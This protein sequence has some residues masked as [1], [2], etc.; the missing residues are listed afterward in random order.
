[1]IPLSA[2]SKYTV[3]KAPKGTGVHFIYPLPRSPQTKL[4]SSLLH[5]TPGPNS[6][7]L[8]IRS[9]FCAYRGGGVKSSSYHLVS[10]QPLSTN[11]E[12]HVC[13]AGKWAYSFDSPV[14]TCN[15][16]ST[17]PLQL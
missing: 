16:S 17:R 12:K 14:L 4:L 7:Q 15:L 3:M 2:K 9:V 1:M 10:L 8:I 5:V 13:K 6:E 11:V